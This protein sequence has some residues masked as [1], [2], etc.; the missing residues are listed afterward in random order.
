[1]ARGLRLEERLAAAAEIGD[2]AEVKRLIA[3]GADV[4]WRDDEGAT[5]LILACRNRAIG[6][7]KLLLDANADPNITDVTYCTTPL[8]ESCKN[9][10]TPS[11][12]LLLECG[13]DPSMPGQIWLPWNTMAPKEYAPIEFA[14]QKCN[15]TIV[16]ALLAAGANLP[17]QKF[18]ETLLISKI[19]SAEE[20]ASM[21]VKLVKLLKIDLPLARQA[22]LDSRTSI[23]C[24]AA[25]MLEA[26]LL[27][28]HAYRHSTNR[29][30]VDTS[31]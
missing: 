10:E 21:Y 11:A 25:S 3:D 30:S 17:S 4:N 8:V 2:A 7:I 22:A 20:N 31:M 29:A 27:E 14:V 18:V 16:D 15:H 28:E 13:A 1:M 24:V 12:L 6:C 19:R 23:G 26:E 9:G 5:A